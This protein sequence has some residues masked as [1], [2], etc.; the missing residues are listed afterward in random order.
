MRECIQWA[1]NHN[2]QP[3]ILNVAKLLFKNKSR[4]KMLKDKLKV[5][6]CINHR[7]IFEKSKE[8]FSG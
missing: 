2:C 1:E 5:K 8:N 3:R 7:S 4:K 6:E